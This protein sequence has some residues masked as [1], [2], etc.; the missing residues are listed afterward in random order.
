MFAGLIGMEVHLQGSLLGFEHLNR[1]V[2]EEVAE[3]SPFVYMQSKEDEQIGF[4][5]ASPFTFYKEYEFELSEQEQKEM[6]II[7]EKDALILGLVTLRDPFAEST[8][9]LLAPIIINIKDG[10]G[11]QTVLSPKYGYET[12]AALFVPGGAR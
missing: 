8:I 10:M 3:N 4:V 12:N 1:Y 9:N 7:S 11:K 5:V 2:F 6:G